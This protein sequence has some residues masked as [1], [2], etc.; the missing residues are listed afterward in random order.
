MDDSKVPEWLLKASERIIKHMNKDHS[1]SI[2][3]TLN[4]QHGI[5]DKNEKMEKLQ[6]S[7]YIV[8]SK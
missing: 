8:L 3:S 7:G 6:V 4:G 1:N 5:K 2:V